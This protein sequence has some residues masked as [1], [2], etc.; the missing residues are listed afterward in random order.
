MPE[1]SCLP[2]Q[3]LAPQKK[4]L[5]ETVSSH[6]RKNEVRVTIPM[7]SALTLTIPTRYVV[8]NTQHSDQQNAQYSCQVFYITISL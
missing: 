4:L 7:A 2:E 1:A 5:L 3:I 8:T 6:D